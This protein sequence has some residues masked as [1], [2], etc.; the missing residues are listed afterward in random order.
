MPF[1]PFKSVDDAMEDWKRYVENH[2]GEPCEVSMLPLAS[3]F[4]F[5]YNSGAIE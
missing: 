5:A 4:V 2:F 3:H 1:N